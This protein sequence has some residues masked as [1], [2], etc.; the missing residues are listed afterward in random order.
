MDARNL[1][2][3]LLQLFLIELKNYMG[4]SKIILEFKNR[5]K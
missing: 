4:K 1:I 3:S 2:K 5:R